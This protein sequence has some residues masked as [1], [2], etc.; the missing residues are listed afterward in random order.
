MSGEQITKRRVDMSDPNPI[1]SDDGSW[2]I[3][4]G[5][6]TDYVRPDFLDAYVADAKTRWG[7][8]TVSDEPDAGPAGYH[9]QTVIP[10]Q[11]DHPEAGQV[12]E[13]TSPDD[14]E[15][16]P[17]SGGKP[18]PFLALQLFIGMWFATLLGAIQILAQRNAMATAYGVAA[19]YGT[20]FTA[21]PGTTGSV[22]GEVTGGAPAFARKAMSWGAAAASAITGTPVFDVPSGTTVTYFGVAVSAT[23]TTAD[24][25]DKVAVTSQAFASQGTYTVTATYT[26]T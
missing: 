8:V 25:R 15:P 23:L 14:P 17:R 2:V 10:E 4:A 21:D 7:T 24:L 12:F 22:T 11:L 20:L 9:G 1:R 18:R 3:P 13:A 6:A 26:Q 5:S 19:P 16:K